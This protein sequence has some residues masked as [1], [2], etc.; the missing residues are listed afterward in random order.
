M[1]TDTEH[2]PRTPLVVTLLTA[3]IVLGYL[4]FTMMS[5]ATQNAIDNAFALFP[6]RFDPANPDAYPTLANAFAPIFGHS[7]LHF[8]WWHAGLN[9][10]FL[11]AAGRFV[12]WRLGWW[13]FLII[14]FAGSAGGALAFVALNWGKDVAAIGA[15]DAVCGMFSAYFM[16]VR[17]DWRDSL[18][19]PM[20]RN[21]FLMIVLINVVLMGIAS[22]LGWFP[23][24]WE[25]HLGGF[26]GGALAYIMLQP[27]RSH[28][29]FA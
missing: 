25:G 29:T 23:I 9:A 24:A 4:T 10:F 3:S 21:Q 22:E 27:R 18:R 5:P 7:F 17:S 20:V 16:A 8:A 12:A 15:S 1:T 2:R 6:Q 26:I 13:R 19:I 14:F 11:F 28:E